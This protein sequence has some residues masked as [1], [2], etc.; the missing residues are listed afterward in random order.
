MLHIKVTVNPLIIEFPNWQSQY[1]AA[2]IPFAEL[3]EEE[4]ARQPSFEFP[5]ALPFTSAEF[6]AKL[7]VAHGAK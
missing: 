5:E 2:I 3:M 7:F 4:I 1:N 6:D